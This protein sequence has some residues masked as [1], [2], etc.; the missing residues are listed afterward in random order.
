MSSKV[1]DGRGDPCDSLCGG[2]GCGKCGALSCDEGAVTKADNA[3][4]LAREAEGLLRNRQAE[5]EEM[6]RGVR[7]AEQEADQSLAL[8]RVALDAAQQAQNQSETAKTQVEELIVQIDEF[9]EL[10]GAS[11][12]DIR[13]LANEVLKKGISL[14][15]EQITDLARRINDTILSLTN[16]DAILSETSDDLASAKALKDRA[17]RAK[18]EAQ[19]ILTVAQQVFDSLA[20]AQSAQERAQE[21]IQTADKVRHFI[22]S[23][24]LTHSFRSIMYLNYVLNELI[25]LK[26][27]LFIG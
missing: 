17:D 12:A 11:P 9:L 20:S 14:Q 25:V 21:V 4:S 23:K 1:C 24:L 15:P 8:A 18:A 26:I 6:M 5:S 19:D 7:M 2:G 10:S 13:S 3:L 16:I 27:D 22:H